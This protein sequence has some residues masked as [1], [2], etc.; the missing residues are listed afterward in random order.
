MKMN[1]MLHHHAISLKILTSEA[2]IAVM[3]VTFKKQKYIQ[4][5]EDMRISQ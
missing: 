3:S 5:T 1:R 2:L 4:L